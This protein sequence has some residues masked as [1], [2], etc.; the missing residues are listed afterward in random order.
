MHLQVQKLIAGSPH[1]LIEDASGLGKT[2]LVNSVGKK[3]CEDH[4]GRYPSQTT[5]N[6]DE[7]EKPGHQM[8]GSAENAVGKTSISSVK[9][10]NQLSDHGPVM[11][12]PPHAPVV[13]DMKMGLWGYSQ[14]SGHQWLIPVMSPSEGL[15][16]KPYPVP[17]FTGTAC[18]G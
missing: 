8:E 18:G 11:R 6:K 7:L 13:P 15:V 2:S 17:G 1:L 9:S 14:S 16:Y 4:N 12:N 10:A 5:N 3:F